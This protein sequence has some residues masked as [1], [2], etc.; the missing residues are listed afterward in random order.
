M[1]AKKT[2]AEK[3]FYLAQILKLIRH[4]KEA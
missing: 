4:W 2:A 3:E 1:V